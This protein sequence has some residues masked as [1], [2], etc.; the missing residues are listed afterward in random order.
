M[1]T[2]SAKKTNLN[3]EGDANV[4]PRLTLSCL[5]PTLR[6]CFYIFLVFVFLE[7]AWEKQHTKWRLRVHVAGVLRRPRARPARLPANVQAPLRGHPAPATPPH[8]EHHAPAK[9]TASARRRRRGRC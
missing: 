4:P 9:G 1:R 5:V 6:F 7:P 2:S 3:C 8:Q